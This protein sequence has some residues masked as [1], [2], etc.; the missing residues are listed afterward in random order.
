MLYG[1]F[2]DVHSNFQ[3]L[4]KVL[5]TFKKNNIENFIYCGDIVGYG[6]QPGECLKAIMALKNLTIVPGN[7]DA[8]VCGKMDA[9]WFNPSA[10]LAIR[11]VNEELSGAMLGYLASLPDFVE[12]EEFSLVHGSPKKHL[13]EY[14]INEEQ[15]L[16][17]LEFWK[18]AVCFIGHS[19]LPMY[20]QYRE[21]G[22]FKDGITVGQKIIMDKT[23]RYIFN[24][25]SVGQPRDGNPLSSCAIY[26]SDNKSFQILRIA[27]DREKTQQLMKEK[28]M[29]QPLIDRLRFGL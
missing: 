7:H 12:N 17:N 5:E 26:D 14:L 11:I 29:P 27:Y 19:H 6:P 2:S 25:G 4:E 24:P 10:L 20:F 3:A 16:N 18:S 13:T 1:V 21:G 22:V 23:A 8:V 28:K 9:K 15:F